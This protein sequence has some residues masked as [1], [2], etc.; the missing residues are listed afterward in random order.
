M[1]HPDVHPHA[2]RV[3]VASGCALGEG[4][5][6]DRRT[7][8][9]LWVDIK[10]P[11]VWRLEAGTGA[12]VSLPVP[13]PVGFV[14][15]TEDPQVV[16]AGFRSGLVRLDLTSGETERIIE[17]EPDEPGNRIN[18]GHVGPNGQLY[19]GTMDDGEQ[20]PTGRFYRWDGK[21]LEP[22]GKACVVTNGPAI[23]PD[24]RT[25]YAVDSPERS[26]YA[27]DLDDGRPGP[28]RQFVR[29]EDGWG[30][31]DGVAVD[32]EG[33]L[34]ACHWGGSRITRFRPDGSPERVVP[35]PTAQV[36]K[37]AFGGPDLTTLYIT[38]A[39]IG[40]DPQIDPM[41]GH[42]FVLETGIRGLPAHI[43]RV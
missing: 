18:D 37:C 32:A 30:H 29:F 27:H 11:A 3:V 28:A 13:E 43:A 21:R 4:P 6:W 8:T 5:V 15:L 26:I 17:P 2:P 12:A 33:C 42:L 16:I 23:G 25:L 31:P 40:R 20:Q 24:G 41:A 34:W 35:V 19:F 36:S 7:G 9:L 1:T 22:F 39:G 38:T 10:A 14:A